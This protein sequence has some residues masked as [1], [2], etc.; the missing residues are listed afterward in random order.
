MRC[1]YPLSRQHQAVPAALVKA[2]RAEAQT[3]DGEWTV[4]HRTEANHQRLVR[5]PLAVRTR[6]IRLV[7]E[8]TWGA[9]TAHLFAWDVA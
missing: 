5:F 4:I 2:F 6:A 8:S 3:G 1:N 7:P 9:P